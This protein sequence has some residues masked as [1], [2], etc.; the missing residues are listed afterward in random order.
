[1]NRFPSS[2]PTT[3]SPRGKAD[4]RPQGLFIQL[5]GDEQTGTKPVAWKLAGQGTMHNSSA[6]QRLWYG[7]DHLNFYLRLDFQSGVQPGRTSTGVEFGFY[8]DRTTAPVPLENLP[9]EPPVNYLFHHQLEINL[10]TQSIQFSGG[11]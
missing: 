11:W 5:L 1:M 3:R 6:I 4:H 2:T 10:L 8:P 9:D 7:L